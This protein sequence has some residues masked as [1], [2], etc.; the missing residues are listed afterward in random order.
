MD[1]F[2]EDSQQNDAKE[3]STTV[4]IMVNR[5]TRESAFEAVAERLRADGVDTQIVTL[6]DVIGSVAR[7]AFAGG[8]ERVLRGLRVA[9]QGRGL[10]EDFLGAV[11]RARPDI[12]AVTNPRYARAL[13]LLE[14]LS[15]ISTLQVGI[16]PDYNL[17]T[18][19]IN[20]S[21]QAFV[22]PTEEHRGRLV[23][24]GL[25]GERVLVA[26]P[27][28]EAG[29]AEDI[30]RAKARKDLGFGDEQVVLVRADSFPLQMVEKIVFQAKMVEGAVRFIFHHNGDGAC[31]AAL[32]RAAD[33]H[34]FAAGMFG[35]VSDLQRFVAASDLV[36]A[37]PSD[38]YVAETLALG[39]PILFVG[40]EDS[41]AAQAEFLSE[42]GAARYV[43]DVLRLSSEIERMLEPQTLSSA[44]EAAVSVGQ[45]D[46]SAQTAAALMIALEN[47]DAWLHE[48]TPDAAKK[49]AKVGGADADSARQEPASS[50]P[51]E[52][53]GNGRSTSTESSSP[54]HAGT[55][56]D[57]ASGSIRDAEPPARKRSFTGISVAEAK[58][59]LAELIL[60]ERDF[61]RRLGEAEK[62]R[63]RWENRLELAIEWKET[64]LAEEARDMLAGFVSDV[65]SLQRDLD[66]V[67]NQKSKLK[68]AAQG[69]S[70]SGSSRSASEPRALLGDGSSDRRDPREVED[71]FRKME[72]DRDLDDLKDKLNR[73]FG[74]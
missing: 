38:P 32:R 62:Q 5:S 58:D 45:Q 44:T 12:L 11:R 72:L 16:L 23:A 56:Q 10:E 3:A 61:E 57:D 54:A 8:A 4:W 42:A 41:G 53:I 43:L 21:L 68:R 39:R 2:V 35:K 36:M 67:R 14:S 50:G 74:D 37:P 64:D 66:D 69:S 48:P 31:A 49:A 60:M 27:A 24:N 47:A 40:G 28:I 63:K 19:W 17:S 15:G 34:A 46:G 26:S 13:G 52:T 55:A 73:D 33:Q 71:R 18:D 25:L 22:V 70:G 7:D 6:S 9:F 30:D 20:S 29:F 51:F 1:E 59:Q 65:H